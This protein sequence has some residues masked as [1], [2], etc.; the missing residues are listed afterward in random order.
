[1]SKYGATRTTGGATIQRHPLLSVV[2]F[3][4][5]FSAMILVAAFHSSQ[6]RDSEIA[7]SEDKTDTREALI[8]NEAIYVGIIAADYAQTKALSP[9]RHVLE[10]TSH[11][12]RPKID[13][14]D[15]SLLM[16]SIN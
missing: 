1:V 13:A 2:V 15:A 12:I 11:Q 16:L 5:S 9:A 6:D 7:A 14:G 8:I 4:V 3:C 10:D